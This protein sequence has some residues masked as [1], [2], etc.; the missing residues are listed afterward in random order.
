MPRHLAQEYDLSKAL[1]VR[2]AAYS[3]L[4]PPSLISIVILEAIQQFASPRLLWR[5]SD[6]QPPQRLA[7][8]CLLLMVWS[9]SAGSQNIQDI[10]PRPLI[11]PEE[12]GATSENKQQARGVRPCREQPPQ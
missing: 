11:A 7:A 2:G 3:P 12:E 10:L 4:K 8:S 1:P 9:T 6:H 5:G